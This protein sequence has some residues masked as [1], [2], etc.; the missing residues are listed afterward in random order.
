MRGVLLFSGGFAVPVGLYTALI[1]DLASRGYAVV[2]FDHPET[3][4]AERPT[5]GDPQRPRRRRR[6]RLCVPGLPQRHRAV[7]AA[8]GAPPP[9]PP[10]RLGAGV[11]LDGFLPAELITTGLDRPFG[12]MGAAT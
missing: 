10:P 12:L 7:H 11:N 1:T 4:V 5:D 3:F 9:P 6:G 2:A 8:V